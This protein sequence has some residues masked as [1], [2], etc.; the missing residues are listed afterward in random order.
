MTQLKPIIIIRRLLATRL[1][2]VLYDEEFHEGINV[3][4]GSNGGGKT[5][6]I[7]MLVYGLGYDVKNWKDEAGQSELIYLGLTIN[8]N[9]ITLRRKNERAEKQSMDICFSPI[10]EALHS[11]IEEWSNFPMR[12]M[13]Q[14]RAFRKSCFL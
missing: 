9:P 2:K 1:G 4:C 7:Q 14:K 13:L 5:S 10:E 3:I 6:V 12:S 8:N 11:P